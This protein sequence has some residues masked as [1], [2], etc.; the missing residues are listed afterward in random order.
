[1]IRLSRLNRVELILNSDLIEQI[2]E[3]PDTVIVLTTGQIVRVRE[4]AR[5]VIERIV[6][7]RRRIGCPEALGEAR[8]TLSLLDLHFQSD[9]RL[10]RLQTRIEED[11]RPPHRHC[12]G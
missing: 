10:E 11:A 5:E 6:E 3:T 12:A 4:S 8:T 7:F 1:M 9:E 2:E